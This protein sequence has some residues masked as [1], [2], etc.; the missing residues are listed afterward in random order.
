M[1]E[2]ELHQKL[3]LLW[4]GREM[5]VKERSLTAVLLDTFLAWRPN[6]YHPRNKT[7]GSFTASRHHVSQKNQCEHCT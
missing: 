7:K 6:G 1:E 4:K 3:F 5:G 2:L